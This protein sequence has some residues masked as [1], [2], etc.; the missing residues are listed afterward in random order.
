MKIRY[1]KVND[2]RDE[3]VFHIWG[4]REDGAEH[5]FSKATGDHPEYNDGWHNPMD[6]MIPLEEMLRK[7]DAVELTEDEAFVE[8]I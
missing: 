7:G 2:N 1:L 3:H 8:L 6:N 4:L 5:M